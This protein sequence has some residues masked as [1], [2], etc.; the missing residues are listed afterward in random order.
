MSGLTIGYDVATPGATD[1]VGQGDDIIRSLKTNL[2]GGLAA[3]HLWPA[4]GGLSGTHLKGSARV[5]VGASSAVSSADTDGR[6]MW[7]STFSRLMYVG[8]SVATSYIGGQRAVSVATI[9][10]PLAAGQQMVMSVVS[11]TT[12]LGDGVVLTYGPTYTGVPYMQVSLGSQGPTSLG[13]VYVPIFIA[14]SSTQVTV[15]IW[16]TK[17]PQSRKNNGELAKIQLVTIGIQAQ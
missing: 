8:A 9:T 10:P 5:F 7:D 13:S 11:S 17:T 16:D 14:A 1:L 3:E 12:T 15:Q 4:A 2:Q 6:M